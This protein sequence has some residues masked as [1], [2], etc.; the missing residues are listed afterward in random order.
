M[1]KLI[2]IATSVTISGYKHTITDDVNTCCFHITTAVYH[3]STN[4]VIKNLATMYL[5]AS[6]HNVIK[7]ERC[8]RMI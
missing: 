7:V 3:G 2:S 4:H 1:H 6:I 8:I 5:T